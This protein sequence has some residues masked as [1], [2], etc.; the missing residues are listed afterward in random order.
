MS[1][2]PLS[3]IQELIERS[4]F[5][6]IR[7]ELVDKEYLPNI[8]LYPN[9]EAGR[10]AYETEIKAIAT[11]KGFAIEVYSESNNHS[12]GIKKTPRIVVKT[13][14]FVPGSLGGDPSLVFIDKGILG[15]EPTVTPPQTVDFYIDFHLISESVKQERILNALLAI[16]VPRRGYIPFYTDATRTFFVKYINF[17]NLDDQEQGIIGKNY[18]YEIQDGWETEDQVVGGMVAKMNQIDLTLNV[19]KY[20]DGSWGYD[21]ETITVMGT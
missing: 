8:N 17:Y 9:T 5:E 1:T 19:Q 12:K 10:L 20:L 21:S 2:T 18:A 4:I 7:K 11:I 3:D 16:A 13:G 6:A 14:S 15:Y